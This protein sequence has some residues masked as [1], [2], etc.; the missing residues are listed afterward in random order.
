MLGITRILC[1]ISRE[2]D[3]LRYDIRERN[4]TRPVVVWNV[5]RRCNLHCIHCYSESQDE[6]YPDE[7]EHG[8][9]LSLIDSL[10]EYG[11]PVLLF[12]G[13]EPL[14]RPDLMELAPYAS[15]KGLRTV[16][17]SNGTLI[18]AS[19]ARDLKKAGFSYIGISLD[20][21]GEIN[22]KFRGKKGAFTEALEGIRNCR[23][24]GLRVGV[25]F[26]ITSYNYKAVPGIFELILSE[27]IPR[28][29]FYHLVYSGRGSRLKEQDLEHEEKR[30]LISYIFQ[31]TL[32]LHQQGQTRDILTVDNHTDAV[33]LY[34]TL[35]R[36][37][38]Q[39]AGEAYRLLKHNGGNRSGIAIGAI[40]NT[41]E[42][43]ADQ[44]WR[45]HSFGNIRKRKFGEIWEDTSDPLMKGLKNRRA[46]I[47]GRCALCKYYEICGANF[48]VRAEAVYD[49]VWAPDPA[50][51]LTDWEIGIAESKQ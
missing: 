46:L 36:E 13:G 44:F 15:K 38:S 25:R 8:E 27:D 48:R 50:C 49:D 37:D 24:A 1:G 2:T 30:R 40:S 41:G 3:A 51:Y 14:M 39:R 21:L 7:L 29:C 34:L 12:S 42:V 26:T 20:G 19:V 17:S 35:L 5:T 18:S 47:K 32:E 11:V 33:F 45:H 10:A 23:L 9:A 16:L 28:C 6:E 31:R 43:Y 4:G 22:D